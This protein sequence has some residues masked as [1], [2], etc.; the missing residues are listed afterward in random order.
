[1]PF[2]AVLSMYETLVVFPMSIKPEPLVVERLILAA[3]LRY[4]ASFALLERIVIQKQ[5]V[6][7]VLPKGE[8]E[9]F[10]QNQ[11]VALLTYINSRYAKEIKFVQANDTLKLE[12]QNKNDSPE[13]VL[14]FLITF[15]SFALCL[16]LNP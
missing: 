4:H 15:C 12:I 9:N 2:S 3:V 1:M 5:K 14:E 7:V 8:R 10:Y 6:I 11:F 16:Y 13:K